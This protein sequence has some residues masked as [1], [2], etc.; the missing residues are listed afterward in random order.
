MKYILPLPTV[1]AATSLI[2]TPQ[3][4]ISSQGSQVGKIM[5]HGFPSLDNIRSFDDFV[6]A[7]DRRNKTAHWVFEHLTF[8]KVKK[9]DGIDRESCK[10]QEDGSV[11]PHFRSTNQDYKNS[12]YDRGHLAAAGNHRWSKQAMEQTFNLS[13]ISPQ[14]GKGFNRD[15]WNSLEKYVR[16][17]TKSYTNVY[18]CTGPLYLPRREPDGKSYV[19]YEVIGPNNVAVPTHFFKVVVCENGSSGYELLSFVMPNQI[20][21]ESVK[22]SNYLVPIESIE[23]SSGLLLFDRI[24]RNRFLKINGKQT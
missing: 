13:N 16:H 21:P 3:S 7:Y 6:L 1:S 19:K 12:G 14:V 9:Q 23:R 18:V 11:H 24:A 17:L 22:L 2:S 15:A 8:D 5:K 4:Q 20:L 10:F